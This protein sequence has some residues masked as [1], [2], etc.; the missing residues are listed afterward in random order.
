MTPTH[1]RI[2]PFHRHLATPL[3][4]GLALF[5]GAAAGQP[6]AAHPP[7]EH[8]QSA[9][10]EPLSDT[11]QQAMP[12]DHDG[13]AMGEMHDHEMAEMHD[14]AAAAATAGEHDHS[15]HEHGSWA[16]TGFERFLA[17]LGAFHPAA[18]NF[19]I[20]LL[21]FAALAELLHAARGRDIYRAS[22]RFCLWAGAITAAGTMVLGWFYAGF[23]LAADDSLLRAHRWN[24]TAVGVLS[25][26]ALWLGE[27]HWRTGGGRGL[28]RA[29]LFLVAILAGLNGYLGG[30][31]LY[32]ADHYDWPKTEAGEHDHDAAMPAHGHDAGDEEHDRDE[33][34]DGGH[35]HD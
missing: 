12:A 15:A 21:L 5:F 33:A 23:D 6:A 14:H 29:G 26:I 16:R 30:R 22:A 1:T 34:G 25:L 28:Y 18:T 3:L 2:L 32:G 9:Q 27:R 24:G 31:M 11:A 10:T 20:A 8:A 35:A 13:H 7:S 4:L 17:W 19:P